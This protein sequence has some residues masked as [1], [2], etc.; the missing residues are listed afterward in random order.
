MSS[1]TAMPPAMY[2]SC[3]V[4]SDFGPFGAGECVPLIGGAGGVGAPTFTGFEAA[5]TISPISKN[6]FIIKVYYFKLS[7]S[8]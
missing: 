5:S 8:E 1:P 3:L 4:A 7:V 6:S 2:S